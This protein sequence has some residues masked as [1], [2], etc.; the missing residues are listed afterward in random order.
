MATAP[1]FP[2]T[3]THLL[4]FGAL[5]AWAALGARVSPA[6]LQRVGVWVGA[7]MVGPQEDPHSTHE[8]SG[9]GVWRP[10]KRASAQ[11]LILCQGVWS[12]PR[13]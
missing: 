4:A 2:D 13:I 5:A 1:R 3:N 6:P 11:I 9:F 7:L 8:D 12:Q 10:H